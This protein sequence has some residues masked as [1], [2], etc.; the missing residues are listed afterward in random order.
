MELNPNHRIRIQ[1]GTLR[2]KYLRFS[3]LVSFYA[4]TD[5]FDI[6]RPYGLLDFANCFT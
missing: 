5:G 6:G 4:P 3:I 2:I 1:A